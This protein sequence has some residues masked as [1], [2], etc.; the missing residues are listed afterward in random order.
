MVEVTMREA[1]IPSLSPCSVFGA[2]ANRLL[3][4]RVADGARARTRDEVRRLSIAFPFL[5]SR[6]PALLRC[7]SVGPR[8]QTTATVLVSQSVS[9]LEATVNFC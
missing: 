5:L 9:Q 3:L 1:E 6:H 8:Q 2:A 4:K 7:N